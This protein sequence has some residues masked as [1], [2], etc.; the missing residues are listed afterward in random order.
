MD[1]LKE[2][3]NL[4]V[5]SVYAYVLFFHIK[6]KDYKSMLLATLITA[7]LICQM[8]N[9]VEGLENRDSELLNNDELPD[10][11]EEVFIQPEE[12]D[13]KPFELVNRMGP[14]DGLCLSSIENKVSHELVSNDELRT[15]LGVQGPLQSVQTDDNVLT[16]PSL[17]GETSD[18]KLAILSNNKASLDCCDS[19]YSTST[20]CVCLTDKQKKYIKSRGFNKSSTDLI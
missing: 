6:D 8:K 19:Q 3:G 11:P 16:G 12:V 18:N 20:G 10:E 17:D 13:V 2:N 4:V 15:Y 9:N 7:I 1:F 5:I 14:Y